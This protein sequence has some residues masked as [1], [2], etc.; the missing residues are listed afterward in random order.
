MAANAG[1]CDSDFRLGLCRIASDKALRLTNS[2]SQV[3]RDMTRKLK[4]QVP[5]GRG[6]PDSWKSGVR[7]EL[8]L[9]LGRLYNLK[10]QNM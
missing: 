10:L 3:R 6:E 9:E 5:P 7:V 2:L 1:P 4:L 8:E